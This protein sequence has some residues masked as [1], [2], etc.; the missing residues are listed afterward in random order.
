MIAGLSMRIEADPASMS[1]TAH[2]LPLP[3]L[4]STPLM[5]PVANAAL[6]TGSTVYSTSI[7]EAPTSP[8]SNPIRDETMAYG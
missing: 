5:L 2:A 1:R 6:L 7:G 3:L 4:S 8:D